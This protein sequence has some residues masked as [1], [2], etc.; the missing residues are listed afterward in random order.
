MRIFFGGER[1]KEKFF[2]QHHPRPRHTPS[3]PRRGAP[4]RGGFQHPK[5][6]TA[7]RAAGSDGA[8]SWEG[9]E[10][11]W[12]ALSPRLE[13]HP[14]SRAGVGRASAPAGGT[15]PSFF[16]RTPSTAKPEPLKRRKVKAGEGRWHPATP[17]TGPSPTGLCFLPLS[18]SRR[19]GGEK[20]A[21]VRPARAAP[22]RSRP[23]GALPAPLARSLG[24]PWRPVTAAC[25]GQGAR[26]RPDQ[27][28]RRA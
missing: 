25:G 20:T 23:P 4:E 3:S 17:G 6:W 19:D 7:P 22:L 1:K 27:R 9:R 15:A 14:S 16:P 12:G 10:S 5:G 2:K 21:A 26:G 24:Q 28:C 18:R 11:F 13:G 8:G